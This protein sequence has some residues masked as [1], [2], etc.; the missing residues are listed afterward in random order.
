VECLGCVYNG[1]WVALE[2]VGV[3][4]SG[5]FGAGWLV[6]GERGKVGGVVGLYRKGAGERR[7]RAMYY[8]QSVSAKK[9]RG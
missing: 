4:V 3:C 1:L 7:V 6:L 5:W 9:Y 2:V 8:N